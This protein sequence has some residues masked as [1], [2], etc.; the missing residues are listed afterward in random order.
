MLIPIRP[1]PNLPIYS[2]DEILGYI[3][4]LGHNVTW[5]IASDE[6]TD[7]EHIIPEYV[8]VYSIAN[9]RLIPGSTPLLHALN[10][11]LNLP[12]I[13]RF[14]LKHVRKNE[15][16]FIFARQDIIYGLLALYIKKRYSI[17]FVYNRS[18]PLEQLSEISKTEGRKPRF[19]WS[20]IGKLYEWIGLYLFRQAD[21]GFV[22][23][24]W[25]KEYLV[26]QGI[27][28]SK[29][30]AFPE[31]VNTELFSA[32]AAES[33]S[34]KYD[35]GNA[36]IVLYTGSLSRNRNLGIIVQAF[37][38]IKKQAKNV[39]LL[40]VGSGNDEVNLKVKAD[41]LG[42]GKDVIFTG[43]VARAE[44]YSLI[45]ISDICVSPIQPTPS[46]ILSSP[47]KILEYMAM[48]KP[49]VANEEI[50]DQKEIFTESKAGLLVPYTPDGFAGALQRLL[51]DPDYAKELGRYGP[52]WIE[53]N[54][55]YPVLA[56]MIVNTCLK[57]IQSDSH[58]K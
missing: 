42:V 41:D 31:G 14:T 4:N 46:Y 51:D 32:K 23:S 26:K 52:E 56:R 12:K 44:V 8:K 35:F 29:L 13:V 3:G 1:A 27:T 33:C 36:K 58:I 38:N 37:A 9:R 20:L 54:R 50:P 21:I 55:S 15:Y 43:Q 48:S 30:F 39:K 34:N 53:N 40:F 6:L 22:I 25:L 11:L 10:R 45:A 18:N 17:P 2:G 16:D 19:L 47:I 49:V 28:E 7:V 24:K 5:I 57:Y